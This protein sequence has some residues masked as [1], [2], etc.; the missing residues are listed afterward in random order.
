VGSS[1]FYGT[2]RVHGIIV[3]RKA[4]DGWHIGASWVSHVASRYVGELLTEIS[5]IP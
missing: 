2:R 1:I 5:G 4:S 3:I